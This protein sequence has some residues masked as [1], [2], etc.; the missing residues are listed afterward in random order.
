MLGNCFICEQKV[1]ELTQY[2]VR[3]NGDLIC[4]ECLKLIVDVLIM[5]LDADEII[6]ILKKYR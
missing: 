3:K 4:A 5:M 1:D 6:E 2:S